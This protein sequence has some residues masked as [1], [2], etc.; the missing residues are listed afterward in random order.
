MSEPMDFGLLWAKLS[1]T[2]GID[3]QVT[4]LWLCGYTVL[5]HHGAGL[6]AAA[7]TLGV[8]DDV[9]QYWRRAKRL[10]DVRPLPHPQ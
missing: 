4:L 2:S 10:D 5:E 6:A 9:S 7:I 8:E 1:K 3:T